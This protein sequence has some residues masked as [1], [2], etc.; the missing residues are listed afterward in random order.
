MKHISASENVP[1]EEQQIVGAKITRAISTR[2][3]VVDNGFYVPRDFK[4]SDVSFD[5]PRLSANTRRLTLAE[6][7]LFMAVYGRPYQKLF[8]GTLTSYFRCVARFNHP[9]PISV[10][11][12]KDSSIA[13]AR[14]RKAAFRLTLG[15]Q[16]SQGAR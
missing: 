2:L 9:H 8:L 1:I 4:I 16:K 6:M 11:C 13:Y 5:V 7:R 14:L 15:E 12:A 10:V 3:E